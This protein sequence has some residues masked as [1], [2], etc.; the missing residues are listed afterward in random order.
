MNKEIIKAMNRKEKKHTFKKWWNKNGYKVMR[1][2]FFP[3]WIYSIISNK[4]TDKII[5]K[6]E[7]NE[8][9]AKEILDYYIPRRCEWDAE[10]NELYFF[11]NGY[12]WSY[13][14]SKRHLKRKHR[15]FWKHNCGWCG[16][17]IRH[18]LI[19]DFELEGFTKEALQCDSDWTEIV[20]KKN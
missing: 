20:F 3:L 6:N 1:V 8:L 10:N 5:R 7:W 16:G 18:F 11:D 9:T 19:N 17:K 15:N 2:I 13:G 14:Y 12:G 4:V